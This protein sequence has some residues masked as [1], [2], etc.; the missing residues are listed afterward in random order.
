[1]IS[2]PNFI[3]RLT[4]FVTESNRIEGIHRKPTKAELAAHMTFLGL[5]AVTVPDIERFVASVAPGHSLRR[6][7]GHNVRVGNHIAPP[8]GPEIEIALQRLLD[9]LPS[10]TPY[11]AHVQFETLHPF[12]DGN[13]RSGRALWLWQMLRRSE[14][15]ARMALGLGFL[16]CWYY[17]TLEASGERQSITSKSG[18][19]P[20]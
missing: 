5:P 15:D 11:A 16:H 17:A 19:T 13:G 3:L 8:G 7:P 12:G 4:A 1:M 14:R 6:E 20:A 18:D 9:D 2:D 10:L